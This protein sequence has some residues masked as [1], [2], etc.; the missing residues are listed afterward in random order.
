M[1]EDRKNYKSES[2]ICQ[3]IKW[4]RPADWEDLVD[5][6]LESVAPLQ[7]LS[8][9]TLGPLP[10]DEYGMRYIVLIVNNFSKFVGLY[11]A[12]TVSTLEFVKAFLSWAGIFGLSKVL[13][14]DEGSQFN[15]SDMAVR[16]K[17]LLKY[18]HIIVFLIILQ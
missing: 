10:E 8:I 7:E 2:I 5:H 9:D 14:S 12:K 15:S 3:K 1:K 18:Q 6:R 13:R 16:L 11:P 4:K 17:I